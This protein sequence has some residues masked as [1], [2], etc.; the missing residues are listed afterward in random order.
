MPPIAFLP[1]PT[2]PKRSTSQIGEEA[3]QSAYDTFVADSASRE[4]VTASHILVE[5][6]DEARAIIG[7]TQ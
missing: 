1:R 7:Q 3:I 5:T 2:S 6:E 4:Q